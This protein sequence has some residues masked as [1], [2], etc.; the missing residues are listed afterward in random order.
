MS[1]EDTL[2][3]MHG[4]IDD[5]IKITMRNKKLKQINGKYL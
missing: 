2:S 4:L 5:V 1:F 3:T